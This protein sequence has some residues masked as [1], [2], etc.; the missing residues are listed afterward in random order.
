MFLPFHLT[1]G[2]LIADISTHRPHRGGSILSTESRRDMRGGRYRRVN[3]IVRI[4][5][6]VM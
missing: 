2:T 5:A 6:L 3:V 1:A 4:A